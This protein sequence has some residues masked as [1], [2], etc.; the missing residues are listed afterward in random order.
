MVLQPKKTSER[1]E[2]ITFIQLFLCHERNI[3]NVGKDDMK[4]IKRFVE[5][6]L[7]F[8]DEKKIISK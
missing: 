7:S 6:V 2:R 1:N 5:T 4:F 3:V 8:T